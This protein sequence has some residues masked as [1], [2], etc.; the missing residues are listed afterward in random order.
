MRLYVC[1]GVCFFPSKV[2]VGLSGVVVIACYVNHNAHDKRQTLSHTI[3]H[4]LEILVVDDGSADG[5]AGV[6]EAFIRLLDDESSSEGPQEGG[7]TLVRSRDD[8][9]NSSRREW[10]P[11]SVRLV[12]LLERRGVAGALNEVQCVVLGVACG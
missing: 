10:G 1:V 11:P 2:C 9:S 6:V 3:T 4:R 12:R 7:Q 5:T 8:S